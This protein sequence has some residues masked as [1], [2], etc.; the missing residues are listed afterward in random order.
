MLQCMRIELSKL[1][2]KKIEDPQ[3]DLAT[4][5]TGKKIISTISHII[6]TTIS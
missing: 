6:S 3:L 5:P 1:L 4:H 2:E